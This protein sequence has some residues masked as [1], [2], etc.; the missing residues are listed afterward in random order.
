MEFGKDCSEIIFGDKNSNL[1]L[2]RILAIKKQISP[3][4]I[5]PV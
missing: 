5:F 4:S 1:I 2:M 3:V